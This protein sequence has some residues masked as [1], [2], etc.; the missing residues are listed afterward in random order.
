MVAVARC[1][2]RRRGEPQFLYHYL[3]VKEG[4]EFETQQQ[5][6]QLHKLLLDEITQPSYEILANHCTAL[7]ERNKESE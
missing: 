5:H 1:R 3:Q 7:K 4:N 2:R 6:N